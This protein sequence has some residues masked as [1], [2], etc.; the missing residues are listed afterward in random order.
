MSQRRRRRLRRFAR[1]G[2][3]GGSPSGPPVPARPFGRFFGGIDQYPGLTI[4]DDAPVGIAQPEEYYDTTFFLPFGPTLVATDT[5]TFNTHYATLQNS[6]LGGIIELAEGTT[7]VN[8]SLGARAADAGWIYIMPT[9]TGMARLGDH[10]DDTAAAV[11]AAATHPKITPSG[12]D[13]QAC[14][15]LPGCRKIRFVGIDFKQRDTDPHN[16]VL[17]E[18]RFGCEDIIVDRCVG[19]A[20]DSIR[21]NCRRFWHRSGTRVA[22]ISTA[23]LGMREIGSDAQ[24]V[25]DLPGAKVTKVVGCVLE[26]TGQGYLSG[27]V[28][29]VNT[30]DHSTA[31]EATN[32]IPTDVEVR[33]N[34]FRKQAKW[35]WRHPKFGSTAETIRGSG[36]SLVVNTFDSGTGV[37]T[38][39][40]GTFDTSQTNVVEF[41]VAIRRLVYVVSGPGAGGFGVIVSYGSN[42]S[43][44]VQV[45]TVGDSECQWLYGGFP[46][47]GSVIEIREQSRVTCK[48]SWECK[49]IWRSLVSENVFEW[50]W[51]GDVSQFYDLVA[52]T[53]P[54]PRWGSG[55][56]VDPGSPDLDIW[57]Q[58]ILIY[59][60]V[61]INTLGVVSFTG[62][63]AQYGGTPIHETNRLHIDNLVAT[64][65]DTKLAGK[66]RH[67]F[68]RCSGWK[69]TRFSF[70]DFAGGFTYIGAPGDVWDRVGFDNGIVS[71]ADGIALAK[72]SA[73]PQSVDLMW[74]SNTSN[75]VWKH[76]GV[77]RAG[78]AWNARTTYP[79]PTDAFDTNMTPPMPEWVI[80]H[81]RYDV[82]GGNYDQRS[83]SPFLPLGITGADWLDLFQ[84]VDGV[85]HASY[86]YADPET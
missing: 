73:G 15:V 60:N 49:Y 63:Q 77:A 59:D 71:A 1:W 56:V 24:G 25:L 14:T 85:R 18:T 11:K 30:P 44:T 38:L 75:S 46:D 68:G 8:I 35:C 26:A 42:T 47:A 53:Q 69:L 17:L 16:Y 45:G 83:D 4:P 28:S 12:S 3:G 40:S 22:C 43:V 32:R 21:S 48:N 76:V 31:S 41:G 6:A 33:R 74:A 54:E 13:G 51:Y 84:R 82:L 19:R 86:D 39:S 64:G 67:I 55:G 62:A 50:N 78:T 57:S 81:R 61:I 20:S 80:D 29:F 9:A 7:L 65:I 10:P 79:D 52:K 37:L 36:G 58:D 23:V 5:T 70:V 72:D 27:G 2:S 34:H 66:L